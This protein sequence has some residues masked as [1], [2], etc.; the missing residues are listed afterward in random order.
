MTQLSSSNTDHVSSTDRNAVGNTPDHSTPSGGPSASGPSAGVSGPASAVSNDFASFADTTGKVLKDSTYNAASFDAA[1]AAAA[2]QAASFPVT[3]S[4]GG[5]LAGNL[6]NPTLHAIGAAAGPIGDGTHVA[7]VT[8]DTKGR[9][10]ALSSVA[11]T[12]AP[13]S[14]TAGGDLSGTFPNP[15]VSKVNAG[16][17]PAKAQVITNGSN[18]I[19]ATA[20]IFNVQ[21]YGAKGDGSTDDTTA[22]NAAITALLAYTSGLT[23]GTL[24]FP[25]G[26]YLITAAL[27]ISIATT[28]TVT[29]KGDGK[30]SSI[31]YQT[32]SAKNGLS[33]TL[34]QTA[35][36]VAAS[37]VEVCDLGFTTNTTADTA[38]FI[39]YGGT[40][41]V[42]TE[43]QCGV[44]V[45]DINIGTN[46]VGYSNTLGWTNGV[47]INNPWKVQLSR[48]N[49][50]GGVTA[51]GVV[52]STG[53]APTTGGN[54]P[55]AGAL[56]TIYG[57]IN[58]LVSDIYGL[59]WQFGVYFGNDP[60]GAAVEGIM[61]SNVVLNADWHGLHLAAGSYAANIQCANWLV[62]QGNSING[63]NTLANVAFYLDGDPSNTFGFCS[64]ANCSWTQVAGTASSYGVY[65]KNMNNCTFTGG[66]IYASAAGGAA[67]L[68]GTSTNN[69]FNGCTLGGGT[70]TVGASC[71]G[72][73]FNNIGSSTF[74]NSGGGTN[75]SKTTLF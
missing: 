6:P 61:A 4:V 15:T 23:N 59:A 9:V 64:F 71:T 65:L 74:T 56:I 33:I 7:A 35:G 14:G 41:T 68:T 39:T 36:H 58:C 11:I 48:I 67:F 2:A 52:V 75:I 30:F 16:S 62:D 44:S 29:V 38:V 22:I 8:I 42:S 21:A 40:S 18:Q 70:I 37:V 17:I 50:T 51:G 73:A 26:T 72:N 66:C 47:Y 57:G 20:G 25:A 60:A 27:A 55:G 45:H 63:T 69:I 13:P 46:P 32:T 12:G 3:G 1:G 43:Y 19:I 49:G 53:T 10:T 34:A 31:I 5:D 54:T 24:Y 28:M